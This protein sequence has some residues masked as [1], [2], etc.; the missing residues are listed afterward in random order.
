VKRLGAVQ[1]IDYEEPA[2]R[3]VVGAEKHLDEVHDGGAKALT[4]KIAAGAETTDEDSG[5]ALQCLVAQ[6]G[7]V[8][9]L[10]LVLVGDAV[11]QAD[12]VVGEREGRDDSVGLVFKAE[13][14][15]LAEQTVLV[16]EA[17]L[18]EELVQ[19]C[20]ATTEGLA[21]RQFLLLGSNEVA[22]GQQ[23]VNGHSASQVFRKLET[24][25]ASW[26]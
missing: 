8:K 9:K 17:I 24:T 26:R 11:R 5:E 21:L 13:E 14:I 16:D 22:L 1:R 25:C 6:V 2:T 23:F 10:L 12:A 4:G 18:G 20:F 19:V 15:S 3:S 7:V